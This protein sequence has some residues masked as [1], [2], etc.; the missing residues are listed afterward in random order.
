LGP[1]CGESPNVWGAAVILASKL[2]VIAAYCIKGVPL[3]DWCAGL[4]LELA[5]EDLGARG[6]SKWLLNVT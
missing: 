3:V 2:A 5:G 4:T 6:C 1:A